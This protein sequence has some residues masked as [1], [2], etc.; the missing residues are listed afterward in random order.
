MVAALRPWIDGWIHLR[1]YFVPY[2][3]VAIVI[4]AY[5]SL[6][7]CALANT[8]RTC[9]SWTK[10]RKNPKV[11]FLV[12]YLHPYTMPVILPQKEA[13]NWSLAPVPTL[14]PVALIS[15]HNASEHTILAVFFGHPTLTLYRFFRQIQR[16]QINRCWG[17]P[18]SLMKLTENN[19]NNNSCYLHFEKITNVGGA[20]YSCTSNFEVCHYYSE[21]LSNAENNK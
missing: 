13:K 7:Y 9:K 6:A 5:L 16:L 18:W 10:K 2:I 1:F 11:Q 15:A 12:S 8:Y 19:T 21:V 17:Y 4:V 3:V 14:P 20:N